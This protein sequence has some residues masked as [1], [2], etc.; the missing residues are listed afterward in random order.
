MSLRM[1][2]CVQLMF[3]SYNN[4][5]A[6]HNAVLGYIRSPKPST[7]DA[8]LS[9]MDSEDVV[10][11]LTTEASGGAALIMCAARTGEAEVFAAVLKAMESRL[12]HEQVRR[13]TGRPQ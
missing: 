8:V 7:V 3:S 2:R 13:R 11:A 12:S 10:I 9:T 4:W 1:M 5:F 6:S